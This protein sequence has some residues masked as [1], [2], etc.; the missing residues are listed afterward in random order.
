MGTLSLGT[1]PNGLA[2]ILLHPDRLCDFGQMFPPS[3]V[4]LASGSL[5]V[6]QAHKHY[7][8]PAS[9]DCS[10]VQQ[11]SADAPTCQAL[12]GAEGYSGEQKSL[13]YP[14]MGGFR[15]ARNE[16]PTQTDLLA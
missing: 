6:R 16:R 14:L 1:E 13:W 4:S 9:L 8:L 5:S 11:R 12:L 7:L 3:P 10:F 2:L 15:T